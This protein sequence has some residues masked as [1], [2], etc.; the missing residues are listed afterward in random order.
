MKRHQF[1][2]LEQCMTAL[3]VIAERQSAAGRGCG[4]RGKVVAMVALGRVYAEQ[5]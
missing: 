4:A 3:V 2:T 1:I 5:V